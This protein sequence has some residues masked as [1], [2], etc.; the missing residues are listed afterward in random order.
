MSIVYAV[1]LVMFVLANKLT[2]SA[3][4]IFLQSTSPLYFLLLSPL[5]LREPVRRIDLSVIAAVAAGAVLL[6]F[7]SDSARATAPDPSR[8][9]LLGVLT[10]LSWALTLA[11]LRWLGKH[12]RNTEAAAATVIAGNV[13]AAVIC[14]PMALPL[15]RIQAADAAVLM[16][17]GVFQIGLAY[18][19]LTRSIRQ[20][21]ALEAATLLLVEPVFNPIWTW[22]AHGERPTSL[23]LLGGLVILSSTF[24]ATWWRS[25]TEPWKAAAI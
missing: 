13:I 9:N 14:V 20:V 4:A 8:G 6:L 5:L 19:L 10:G 16:Y 17:L 3:N 24:G 25:R 21:P 12:D 11:G 15:G 18:F 23:A 2:T 1:T 22:L 7:G